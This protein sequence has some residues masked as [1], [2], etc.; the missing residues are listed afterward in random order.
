[1]LVLVVVLVVVVVFEVVLKYITYIHK[2][3]LNY[4]TLGAPLLN[5]FSAQFVVSFSIA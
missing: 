1:M 4:I 3:T 2:S 5:V